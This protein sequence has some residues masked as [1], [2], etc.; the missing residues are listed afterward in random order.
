MN[1]HYVTVIFLLYISHRTNGRRTL[2][3]FTHVA[4]TCTI[5]NTIESNAVCQYGDA[6]WNCDSGKKFCIVNFKYL[7]HKLDTTL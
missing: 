3:L 4:T 6:V 7:V 2:L 5:Q 1:L